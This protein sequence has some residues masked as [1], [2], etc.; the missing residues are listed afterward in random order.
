MFPP[1]P[2]TVPDLMILLCSSYVKTHFSPLEFRC[3][4]SAASNNMKLVHWSL[5]VGCDIWYSYRRGLG[6]AAALPDPFSM[7]Q[8]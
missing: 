4:Y 7:Y 5:W 8:M 6:G 2:T 1:H 3:N